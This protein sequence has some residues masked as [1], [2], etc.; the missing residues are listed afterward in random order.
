[1]SELERLIKELR[2][3]QHAGK[4]PQKVC[5]AAMRA[6]NLIEHNSKSADEWI[7]VDDKDLKPNKYYLIKTDSGKWSPF[8]FNVDRKW[9][10]NGGF[11]NSSVFTGFSKVEMK[12]P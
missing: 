2:L 7:S 11:L 9:L 4:Y 5:G 1:M 3:I 8:L 10:V 12:T 6:A